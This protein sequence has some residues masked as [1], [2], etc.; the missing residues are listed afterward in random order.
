G[1]LDAR[2]DADWEGEEGKFF[3]GDG[4]EI[5]AL[6]DPEAAR[7]ALQYWGVADGPNFEGRSILHVPR[8]PAEVA[9]AL[10]LTTD[11]LAVVLGRARAPLVAPRGGRVTPGRDENGIRARTGM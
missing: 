10:G 2:Q 11:A 3:R 8:E 5:E 7:V 4:R 1:G 6:L 9:T